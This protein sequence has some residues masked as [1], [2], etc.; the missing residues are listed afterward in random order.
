MAPRTFFI[1]S[2]APEPLQVPFGLINFAAPGQ[3]PPIATIVGDDDPGFSQQANLQNTFSQATQGP[4]GIPNAP[5]L[6]VPIPPTPSFDLAASPNFGGVQGPPGGDVFFP[7]IQPSQAVAPLNLAEP[8]NPAD[9]PMFPSQSPSPTDQ[10]FIPETAFAP[11]DVPAE[12][13]EGTLLDVDALEQQIFGPELDL[14]FIRSVQEQ[15]AINDDR[16]AR[17]K[18]RQETLLD[19]A[20][21]QRGF[22]RS[23][24][25]EQ[26]GFDPELTQVAG[27]L[28]PNEPRPVLHERLSPFDPRLQEALLQQ[29]ARAK[30]TPEQAA[31]LN[32]QVLKEK[33]LTTS[34]ENLGKSRGLDVTSKQRI[35]DLKRIAVYAEQ[36]GIPLENI[37]PSVYRTELQNALENPEQR[38]LVLENL[39]ASASSKEA[40]SNLNQAKAELGAVF[41]IGKTIFDK[42]STETQRA[43][44]DTVVDILGNLSS[45]IKKLDLEATTKKKTIPLTNIGIGEEAV[46]EQ[47]KP[48]KKATQDE[49]ER[50]FQKFN[51]TK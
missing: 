25:P 15:Q 34:A 21:T 24:F 39:K 42:S 16:K 48:G 26:L 10:G 19:N 40:A 23:P 44:L 18:F 20:E 27:P 51:P 3:T 30:Q 45:N 43:Y 13:P 12:I 50:V 1:R 17:T 49:E 38:A 22:A 47:R 29:Q 33:A 6:G 32:Q 14:G 7:D 46:L 11:V 28:Q 31:V 4:G 41:S 5:L 36:N 8:L 9:V 35:E 37:L 2:S